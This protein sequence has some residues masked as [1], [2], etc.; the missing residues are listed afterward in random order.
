MAV[1][2]IMEE[3]T[4][5]VTSRCDEDHRF[6]FSTGRLGWPQAL[7]RSYRDGIRTGRQNVMAVKVGRA[8]CVDTQPRPKTGIS[9]MLNFT[10][11]YDRVWPQASLAVGLIFGVAWIGALG[12][13]LLRLVW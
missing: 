9:V 11:V 3:G 4:K 12:Y 6:G 8:N 1:G 10:S 13:G 2:P 7:I 5:R